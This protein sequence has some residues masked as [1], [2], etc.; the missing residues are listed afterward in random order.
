MFRSVIYG[1]LALDQRASEFTT[2]NWNNIG[3]GKF[4]K[5]RKYILKQPALSSQHQ[6]ENYAFTVSLT[7]KF[8]RS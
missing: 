4:K 5:S 1:S 6:V 3:A 7:E 2:G 8:N